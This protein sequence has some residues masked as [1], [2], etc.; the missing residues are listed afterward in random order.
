MKKRDI[1]L[2]SVLILTAVVF[3]IPVRAKAGAGD[4]YIYVRG[5]LYGT[6]DLSE[7]TV[8][9]IDNGNGLVNEIE[10]K[11]NSIF[12]KSATCPGRQCVKSGRIGRNGESI[13]C[14]PAGILIVIRS[15]EEAEYDAITK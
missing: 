7:D 14:A 5:E 10:I 13:C 8:F 1:I 15:N 6:Y 4:A 3:M 11:D 2:I 12:M 9:T